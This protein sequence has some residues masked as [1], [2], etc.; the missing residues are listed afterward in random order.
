M[1]HLRPTTPGDLPGLSELFVDRFGHPLPVEEW[2]WKYR[3]VA[4]AGG[5]GRSMVAVDAG[6]GSGERI[7]AHA[8]ALRLPALTAEGERSIWQLTDWAGTAGGSGLR[9]PLGRLGRSFLADLPGP[10]GSGDAPWIFGFPS[11]RHLELGRHLFGYR[12]LP[13][14]MPVAGRLP[15]ASPAAGPLETSDHCAAEVEAMWRACGVRGVRR[16]AAFL[17]WRYHARPGRYYRF[18]RLGVG[19]GAAVEGLAVFAFVGTEAH[20]VELWLPPPAPERPDRL[21]ATARRWRPALEAVAADLAAAGLVAWTFW[22]PPP[23]SGLGE[24]LAD[25]GLRPTGESRTMGW[26]GRAGGGGSP[27]PDFYYAMGDYDLL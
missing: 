18:Y 9:P 20:A 14:I 27:E 21:R 4:E 1:I 5:L 25:L 10:P 6:P 19:D 8:G 16:T 2:E 23:A 13:A 11:E 15:P 12:P 26:R 24:L 3:R 7:V 22:P 17:N